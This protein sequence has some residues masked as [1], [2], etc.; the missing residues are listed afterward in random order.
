M[1]ICLKANEEYKIFRKNN[2]HPLSKPN[3][4]SM[5]TLKMFW[6]ELIAYFPLIKHGKGKK[7]R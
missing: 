6:E 3:V 1:D 2:V 5:E 4:I 7:K